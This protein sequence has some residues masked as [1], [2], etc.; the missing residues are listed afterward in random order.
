MRNIYARLVTG[1]D[2]RT[3]ALADL[4]E[5]VRDAGKLGDFVSR[6]LLADVTAEQERAEF[7]RWVSDSAGNFSIVTQYR[8]DD[9][10]VPDM[11]IFNG[12][13]PVC[14]V[15]VK[16]DA[17]I[18]ANQLEG[19]G[20][21]LAA[22]ANHRY[23]PALVLLTHVTAP[24][25]G[26]IDGRNGSYGVDLRGVASWNAVAEWFAEL[27]V[28]QDGLDE[29]LKSLAG[30]FGAHLKEE[31]M[32]TLD[33]AAIAR[34]YLARSQRRLSQ[35]VEDMQLGYDFPGQWRRGR[36]VVSKAVGIWKYHYPDPPVEDPYVYSGLCFKPADENDGALHGYI[37]YENDSINEPKPVVIGDGFYAFV[38]I[39]GSA[40]RLERVPGFTKSRWYEW[41]DGKLVK[42]NDGVAVD[43]T[44]WWHYSGGLGGWG[45]YARICSLQELVDVDGR[46]GNGLKSWSHESLEKT[47]SLWSAVYG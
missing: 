15:E 20:R 42:S 3:E 26:F 28:E 7:A 23:R 4:L 14:V 32:S 5:R 35:A 11:V 33:D 9:G 27:C 40:G 19:Y 16:I 18:G 25:P 22:R 12:G 2:S 34:Q 29:P 38:G 45:G 46:L 39:L 41:T 21:W 6:V 43:S 37:R 30:E 44:G 1:E 13:D 17:R 31:A 47:V 24:P 8:I 36:G 10:T